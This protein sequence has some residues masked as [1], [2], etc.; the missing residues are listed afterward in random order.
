[1]MDFDNEEVFESFEDEFQKK[2]RRRRSGSVIP[3][4]MF[5]ILILAVAASVFLIRRLSAPE[6]PVPEFTPS[7]TEE[8]VIETESAADQSLLIPTVSTEVPVEIADIV[9]SETVQPTAERL[10]VIPTIAGQGIITPTIGLTAPVIGQSVS[11]AAIPSIKETAIP[12]TIPSAAANLSVVSPSAKET[13][14]PETIPSVA[15]NLSVVSPSAPQV[16]RIIPSISTVIPSENSAALSSAP[17]I[18][19]VIPSTSTL[20]SSENSAVLASTRQVIRIVPTKLEETSVLL[21]S[22]PDDSATVQNTAQIITSIATLNQNLVSTPSVEIAASASIA[23]SAMIEQTPTESVNPFEP[24]P[25][26][27][28][29]QE[30]ENL[31]LFQRFVD[32][33]KKLTNRE[34]S[35]STPTTE[36]LNETVPS[37]TLTTGTGFI[38]D[39][40][41]TSELRPGTD[42]TEIMSILPQITAENP[43]GPTSIPVS[44]KSIDPTSILSDGISNPVNTTISAAGTP[45]DPTSIPVSGKSIDPTSVLPNVIS[46]PINTAVP[47]LIAQIQAATPVQKNPEPTISDLDDEPLKFEDIDYSQEPTPTSQQVPEIKPTSDEIELSRIITLPVKI[48]TP[49]KSQTISAEPGDSESTIVPVYRE[50]ELPETGFGDQLNLPMLILAVMVLLVIILSVRLLRSKH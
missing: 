7:V 25:E 10:L 1:M 42:A 39:T 34:S 33:F 50:T 27:V 21:Q 38:T 40:P 23:A 6:K 12:E 31:N 41:E 20:I 36:A 16:V 43:A 45:A 18:I 5:I 2:R 29:D 19:Q 49:V 32:F 17:Q 47:E 35:T 26:N 3:P 9:P 11:T 44:G 14:V 37:A 13:A 24:T 30:K 28:T 4:W 48:L 8:I 22:Q 15:A 46:K